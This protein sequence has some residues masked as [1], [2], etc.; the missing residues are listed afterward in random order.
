MPAKKLVLTSH[1]L[2]S[3]ALKNLAATLSARVGYKVLR[4]KPERVR[5]RR[6]VM[7]HPGI[8][9]ITQ[10]RKFHEAGVSAP[11]FATDI[12]SCNAMDCKRIVARKLISSS[13]GKGIE[14]FEKGAQPPRAPLYT[15][16][17]PKKKEFRVHVYNAE[18]IDVAQ[19]RKRHE[20]TAE[21][22]AFVRNTANGY[23]FC[24]DNL[25]EPDGLRTVAVDAVKSLGRIQGAVDVIWHE[26]RD[27]CYVLEV[28]SRPGMEGTTLQ[29]YADA[30]IKGNSNSL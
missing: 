27:K 25:V 14:V 6:A 7:F 5:N 28:N 26:K 29:K 19:K 12:T 21:R 4:V 23:V 18:V 30:I 1:N 9:K 20:H 22:D 16:Y 13:E 17:I 15:E 8:D 10:F 2:K 3:N 11:Q 24:R